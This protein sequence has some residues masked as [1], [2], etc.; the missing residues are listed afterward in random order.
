MTECPNCGHAVDALVRPDGHLEAVYNEL[1]SSVGCVCI[2]GRQSPDL[3]GYRVIH[4]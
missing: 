3:A 4:L 2:I 1:T